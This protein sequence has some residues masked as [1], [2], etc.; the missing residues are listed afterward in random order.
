MTAPRAMAFAVPGDIETVTGGYLY[1]RR[2]ADALVASGIDLHHLT[3]GDSFPHPTARD[4]ANALAQLDRL[5]ASC[6][7]LV[8]GL[9]FGALDTDRLSQVRAPLVALVHH[10]LALEPGLETA[11]ARE[12][13]AREMANL[14]LARHIVVTS[15]HIAR[16]LE[17]EY[18][19]AHDRISIA[20]P[21][22]VRNPDAEP[23]RAATP[24]LILSVG[25]LARRKGHDILMRALA[26]INDLDWQSVI[27]G[28]RHE[29]DTVRSLHDLR[30]DLGLAARVHLTGEISQTRLDALYRE[31]SLF[32]LS[33]R[34]EGYGIVFDEAMGHAL[35]IVSTRAGATPDTVPQ[36][37]GLLVSP[38]DVD[39]FA[40][41]LRRLLGDPR[42]RK[43]CSEAA[44]D[45]AAGLGGWSHAAEVVSAALFG[46]IVANADAPK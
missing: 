1:D 41:A 31:A 23:R 38:D 36:A 10:P 30:E 7:A 2:L 28:R 17:T 24:P 40:E 9:A 37:A 44:R 21:G 13:A 42:L 35:P 39:A 32:A 34:Y 14:A 8:D 45:A 27:V 5:P 12:M 11:Q 16:L 6:P 18:G 20:K 43:A 46:P 29:P 3:L 4:M 15:P 22:F 33:T 19:V 26:Q 25:L